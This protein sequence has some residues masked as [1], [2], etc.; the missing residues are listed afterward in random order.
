MDDLSGYRSVNAARGLQEIQQLLDGGWDILH[1]DFCEE[2]RSRSGIGGKS[3]VLAW[4]PYAIMGK[5]D[6]LAGT[7]LSLI[8]I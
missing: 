5:P 3:S 6:T 7:D 1:L 2:V 8:H 4:T